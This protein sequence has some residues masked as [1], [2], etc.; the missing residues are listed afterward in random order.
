M[1][2]VKTVYICQKCSFKN[3]KWEGKCPQCENW[4]T[5]VEEVVE[6]KSSSPALFQTSSKLSPLPESA[7]LKAHRH[8]TGIKELDRVLGG[9]F[10]SGA[11]VLLGGS[12]G[13][14][15]STLV[16]QMSKGLADYGKILYVCSEEST[17]QVSQRANRLQ[18]KHSDIFLF[19]ESSIEKILKKSTEIKPRMLII[20]SIQSVYFSELS[21]G[22]GSIS[23]VRECAGILMGYAKSTNTGILAIGHIT[24]DGSLAGPKILEHI[25]DTVLSFEGHSFCRILKAVK[26]RFGATNEVGVFQMS[27]KGLKEIS[28]PS[29]FFLEERGEDRIGSTVFSG[30]EGNRPLLCEIQALTLN[31]FL[32]MPRRTSIGVD[33][34][35]LHLILAV[36]EKYFQIRFSKYDVFLNL[37]GGLRITETA[38]DLAVAVSLLS[39]HYKQPVSMKACFFGEIGLTGE[40]RSCPFSL[41]RLLEAQKIGFDTIYLP[42]GN[43]QTLKEEITAKKN[44]PKLKIKK[45]KNIDQ[46][47][48]IF[49]I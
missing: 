26:N 3:L 19:N 9:G 5:F 40:V 27:S 17:A 11:F 35:R 33:I 32:T 43:N 28:N 2:S 30:M 8:S 42:H 16:L 15:K 38:S 25:V 1:S 20:D 24:K 29:Q 14:G 18:V 6:K 36:L 12:P 21:S 10:V 23:Q 49:K 45:V 7:P 4:N 46:L 47:N 39:S 13:V 22:A 37:V 48:Q 34:H 41:E 31:S 44:K